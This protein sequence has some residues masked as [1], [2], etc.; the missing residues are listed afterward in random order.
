MQWYG[1]LFVDMALPFGL[2]SAPKILTALADALQWI[3]QDR[4]DW[5]IHYIDDFLSAGAP[6][7]T[8]CADNLTCLT[9]TCAEMGFPLKDDKVV[10]PT[11][12]LDFLGIILDTSAMELRLPDDKVAQLETLLDQ[13]AS[14]RSCC[15]RD[16]LSLIGKL[17]HACKIVRVGRIFL[18][19]FIN[20]SMKATKPDHWIHLSVDFRAD[21]AWWQAFLRVWNHR[22]MM[23]A[24][25]RLSPLD[26]VLTM[27]ASGTWG[28]GA[29]W[30]HHWLQWQWDSAWLAHQIAAKEL[31]P[32]IL[33]V[34]VWGGQW[35]C[36]SVL[37]RCD[38]MA[39][40]QVINALSCRDPT[41]MHLL[42][43]LYYY[44]ALFSIHI[45]AE[46]IPGV[47]NAIA[48][49]VSRNLL[50]V[51]RQLL[52]QADLY[53]TALSPSLTHLLSPDHQAWLLP[54]WRQLLINSCR[55]V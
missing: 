40:V 45:R 52:P 46:H 9:Q 37:V 53:P 21:I 36:K 51:F 19:R 44:C 34:A 55:T 18:R 26:L 28:C 39:V 23:H 8:Q 2:R 15:K 38:N 6:A 13:W 5:L 43:C 1:R 16:L 33:A 17:A 54:A 12:S 42:R 41:L 10:G 20:Y 32:I 35:R 24:V 48:D 29:V 30:G 27:D 50:Q 25:D 11:T 4:V 14:R 49:S 31:V 3:V 7:S 47:H 22:S